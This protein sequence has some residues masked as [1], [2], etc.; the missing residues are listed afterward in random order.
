MQFVVVVRR[1]KHDPITQTGG[2]MAI[3]A[4]LSADV[5]EV[6]E[7]VQKKANNTEGALTPETAPQWVEDAAFDLAIELDDEQQGEAEHA[8]LN[9]PSTQRNPR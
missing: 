6:V 3:D 7:H 1:S 5:Q 2:Q 9:A 4:V 8:I